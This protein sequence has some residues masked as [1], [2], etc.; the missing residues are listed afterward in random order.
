MLGGPQR[1]DA[2]KVPVFV[3][4]GVVGGWMKDLCSSGVGCQDGHAGA[5]VI[6]I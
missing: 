2:A 6:R 5:V 1:L 3:L 4:R